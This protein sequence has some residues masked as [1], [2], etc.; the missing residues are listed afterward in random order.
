M[1]DWINEWQVKMIFPKS[2][3][4]ICDLYE[5]SSNLG[6]SPPEQSE[7]KAQGMEHMTR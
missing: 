1:T 4:F 2:C 6:Q 3:S 5:W 7:K